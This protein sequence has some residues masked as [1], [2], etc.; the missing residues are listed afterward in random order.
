MSLWGP[1]VGCSGS[2]CRDGLVGAR[3]FADCNWVCLDQPSVTGSCDVMELLYLI[4]L[5]ALWL[6]LVKWVLP[7]FGAGT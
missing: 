2:A 1:P 3:G 4:G 6:V 7:K 5:I